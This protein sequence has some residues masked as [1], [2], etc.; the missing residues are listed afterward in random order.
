MASRS[1]TV[2]LKGH[3]LFIKPVRE[4]YY[5]QE[6]LNRRSHTGPHLLLGWFG[7]FLLTPIVL[8]LWSEWPRLNT[9][10]LCGTLNACLHAN[11]GMRVSI[12]S[13]TF[14]HFLLGFTPHFQP[15]FLWHFFPFVPQ[16][17]NSLLIFVLMP[18]PHSGRGFYLVFMSL[19]VVL[20]LLDD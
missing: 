19:S 14:L 1:V 5:Q 7:G 10:P 16:G 18:W 12:I 20:D 11:L 9:E 4:W 8:C 6:W 15:L 3:Q 13:S 17:I 2:S